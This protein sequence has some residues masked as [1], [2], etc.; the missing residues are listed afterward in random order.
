[1]KVVIADNLEPEVVEE[2]KTIGE[3]DYKPKDLAGS[4]KNAD[5]LIV[6]S[7]TKVTKELLA[8]AENLRL[9]ARAG[10]GLDNIDVRECE[11]RKIKII[12]TPGASSNAVAELAIGLIITMLRNVQK[13]HAQ[14]KAGTWDKKNLTGEEVEG[15]TLGIIGYGRIG[16]LV[17]KKAKAL[18]MTVIAHDPRMNKSDG[19]A[20]FV[21]L[22][23]VYKQA[24]VITLHTIANEQTRNMIN[25]KTMENMKNGVYIV[26]LARGELVDED[27][28]YDACKSGKVKAAAIDV[29]NKEPYVGKLLEL[30]N[31]CFT[32]HLGAATKEAQLRIGNELVEKLRKELRA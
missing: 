1:M 30:D 2:L 15:K 16:S 7:A 4:L 26:N 22:Y 10:V 3:I 20:E 28:L 32:P 29:Y 12:N 23:D 27:A 17:G 14:M 8:G 24:D 6:R 21:S 25:A 5:V 9:V 19:V 31:V 13:A 18:G 11:L